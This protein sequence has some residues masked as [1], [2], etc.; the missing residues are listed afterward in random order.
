M[1][2]YY[3]LNAK[4]ILQF[5]DIYFGVPHDS[6]FKLNYMR[7]WMEFYG[8]WLAREKGHNVPRYYTTF[9]HGSVVM[10]NFGPN[11]GS[12]LS[13]NHFAIVLNGKDKRENNLLTVVPLSSK[14]HSNYLSL[15]NELFSSI[16][17]LATKRLASL[18]ADIQRVTN[19][20]DEQLEKMNPKQFTYNLDNIPEES[21]SSFITKDSLNGFAHTMYDVQ[22]NFSDYINLKDSSKLKGL[23]ADISNIRDKQF[24]S[25]NDN[26]Y[27][28]RLDKI[29]FNLKE[30]YGNLS[31]AQLLQ[32]NMDNLKSLAEKL[33]RYSKNT[34]VIIPNV[35][36]ISKLRVVK[37]SHY[38]IS[39]NVIVSDES[40][41]KIHQ[42]I[43]NFQSLND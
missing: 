43:R 16:Y 39:K 7:E 9:K 14:D 1:K 35:T 6:M 33:K 20:M 10:V 42:S 36:T 21:I 8:Y 38:T 25:D 17:L 18:V 28:E 11:I 26:T 41:K 2:N 23:I 31:N 24:K 13:G 34:F 19:N 27:K 29:I 22:Q 37:V 30:I 5:N 12:E 4:S 40:M 15:G 3:A 32:E